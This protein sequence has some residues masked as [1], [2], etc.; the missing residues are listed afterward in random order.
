MAAWTLQNMYER[1]IINGL[2]K[3]RFDDN[4]GACVVPE[5]NNAVPDIL[6]EVAYEIDWMSK[7]KVD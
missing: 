7:M 4:S 2:N 5:S 6:D 3:E 1:T